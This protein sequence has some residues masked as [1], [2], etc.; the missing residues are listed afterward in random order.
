MGFN[1][2][3]K[4]LNPQ[5]PHGH[6]FS[7]GPSYESLNQNCGWTITITYYSTYQSLHN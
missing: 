1:S 4:E 3:F 2:A 5:I 7:V 6:I